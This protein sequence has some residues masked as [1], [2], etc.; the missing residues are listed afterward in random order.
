MH[1]Y[2]DHRSTCNIGNTE[3][4]LWIVTQKWSEKNGVLTSSND[5]SEESKQEGF[6][7]MSAF[8]PIVGKKE[9]KQ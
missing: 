2:R 7:F 8:F 5:Q 6:H 3:M 4:V 9:K 1:N